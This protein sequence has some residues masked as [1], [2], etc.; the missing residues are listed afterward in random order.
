MAKRKDYHILTTGSRTVSSH[1]PYDDT[2]DIRR[3]QI[4]PVIWNSESILWHVKI[5]AADPDLQLQR[6]MAFG[7]FRKDKV[8]SIKEVMLYA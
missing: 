1:T 3:L 6:E 5:F 7:F 8:E 4:V 2:D